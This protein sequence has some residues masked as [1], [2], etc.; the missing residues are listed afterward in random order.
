MSVNNRAQFTSFLTGCISMAAASV[1]AF[2]FG[3]VVENV[4][5][6]ERSLRGGGK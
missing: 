4:G 5:R 6:I 3:S 2:G 1:F